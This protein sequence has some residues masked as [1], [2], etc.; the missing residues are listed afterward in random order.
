MPRVIHFELPAEDPQRAAKFYADVFGW[1]IQQWG[2]ED[3]WLVMTG[4]KD[5]PGIDGGMM[6]QCEQFP[7]RTPIN[8][9]DV[10]SV[11]EYSSKIEAAGG[12]ILMPK[13]PVPTVGWLAYAQ[14]TEG[15][16]FGI[17]QPDPNAA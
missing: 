8:V 15:V 7:A 11:D 5:K 2:G 10:D 16:I 6:R 1:Q 3:Y 17:M 12:K 9:L 13:M 14:D 4:D